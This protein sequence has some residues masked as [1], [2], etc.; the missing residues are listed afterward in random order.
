MEGADTTKHKNLLFLK[1]TQLKYKLNFNNSTMYKDLC[2]TLHPGRDSNPRSYV[3]EADA[4]T[5][6]PRRQGT[7]ILLLH[8]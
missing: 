1:Y 3:Q 5:T 2:T 8:M 7:L 4:M 6:M